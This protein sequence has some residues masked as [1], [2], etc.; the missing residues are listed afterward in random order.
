MASLEIPLPD[1]AQ[2]LGVSWGVA[3]RL[4]LRG[5]LEARKVGS[6]WVISRESVDRCLRQRA[7]VP[8]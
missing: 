6:R 4:A 1:A 3:W 2:E 7:P 5:E 8:A